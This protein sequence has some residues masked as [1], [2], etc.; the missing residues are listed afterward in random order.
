MKILK[1]SS[2]KVQE[3]LKKV[4]LLKFLTKILQIFQMKKIII[5]EITIL[6][7]YKLMNHEFFFRR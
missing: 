5:R 7:R 6:K 2:K 1:N 3:F 4:V